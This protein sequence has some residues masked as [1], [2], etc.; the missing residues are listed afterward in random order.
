MKVKS[1]QIPALSRQIQQDFDAVLIYGPDEGENQHALTQLKEALHLMS[2]NIT[3]LSKEALQKTPFLATDEANTTSL[4]AD[5]RFLLVAQDASFS[6]E[7]LRDFLQNKK[8]NALLFIQG[9]NL[10]KT[11]ALRQEA[12]SNPRVLAI[13][14]YQP[15]LAEIQKNI[16][17][18]LHQNHKKIAPNVLAM[19]CQKIS[20]NQQV[21]QQEL[22]K[23]LL[24]VGTQPEITAQDV[25][26][27]LT[28]STEFSLDDFCI[29]LADGRTEKVVNALRIFTQSEESETS[30]LR[31]VRSYFERLLKI[32]SSTS[33][34]PEQAVQNN[35]KPFQFHLKDPLLRQMCC[36]KEQTILDVLKKLAELEALTRSTGYP[37]A[38]LIEHF[39]LGLATRSARLMKSR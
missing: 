12:E 16:L 4:I 37:K 15:A 7:A 29:D 34:P 27:C 1:F 19:L 24:Y 9:G 35:L 10:S 32:V 39:F 38:T 26:T 31:S 30:L 33:L 8:T 5:R 14:C 18:Y 36:W 11:N 3:S 20:F 13:I 21:I 22:E 28:T 17:G 23:L 25:Q 2:D 6:A